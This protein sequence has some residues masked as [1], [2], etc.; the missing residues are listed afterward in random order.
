MITPIEFLAEP[1]HNNHRLD[2]FLK[3]N[4]PNISRTKIQNDIK[5]SKVT[6]NNKIITSAKYIVKT[7]DLVT[8]N[9]HE[10]I[11]NETWLAKKIPFEIIFEDEHLLIINKPLNLTMHPGAGTLHNTLANGILEYIPTQASLDRAGIIHRLDKNTSGCCIVA[12]TTESQYKLTTMM[13]NRQIKRTYIALAHG[14][15]ELASTINAPIGRHPKKRTLM[16]VANSGKI[17]I[18]HCRPIIN[19]PA[20][21]LLEVNLETGR[22]HQ[23]RV[24]LSHINHS[25]VGDKQ[26]SNTFCAPKTYSA[27]AKQ[28]LTN[29]PQQA[30]H[31]IQLSLNHP[32]LN[33]E[34]K[35]QATLPNDFLALLKALKTNIIQQKE[36]DFAKLIDI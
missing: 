5:L 29:Y 21:T 11:T 34:I 35:V 28:L 32:I 7:N 1:T 27:L 20:H 31:A 26:Y 12:K 13:Q 17:A 8:Y 15:I 19:Y 18:T 6:V 36:H 25:I 30:L 22:T 23:I 4:L 24:H 33:N 2:L 3:N 10:E 16:A 9:Q 14:V